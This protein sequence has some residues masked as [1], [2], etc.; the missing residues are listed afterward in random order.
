MFLRPYQVTSLRKNTNPGQWQDIQ[1]AAITGG[2]I[3]D[4]P[5]FT[6]A[7]GV[8]NNVVLHESTR[9][10]QS[11][12]NSLV[13]RAVLCGAQAACI[14]FG[15]GYGKNVFSWKE[16]LFDYDNQL[17]VAAGCQ[18]G[19]VKTRF[20]NSDYGVVVVPTYATPSV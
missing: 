4:N 20:D 19:L 17:G 11:P 8:Y 3:S 6:G 18:A 14:A 15:R 7:L 5:I 12:N 9:I 2:Q 16:E 1:K 10:P 13:Y